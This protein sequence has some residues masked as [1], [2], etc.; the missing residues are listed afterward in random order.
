MRVLEIQEKYLSQ[1]LECVG[2]LNSEGV[3]KADL[4]QAKY[5]LDKSLGKKATLY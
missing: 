4:N 1:Y 2:D 3:S 5:I